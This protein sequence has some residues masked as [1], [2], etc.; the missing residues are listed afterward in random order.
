MIAD[1]WFVFGTIVLLAFGVG[2]LGNYV[3]RL[4]RRITAEHEHL[5]DRV[6]RLEA[7]HIQSRLNQLHPVVPAQEIVE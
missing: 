2:S 4:Q 1:Y 3:Y 7:A 5:R 6:C